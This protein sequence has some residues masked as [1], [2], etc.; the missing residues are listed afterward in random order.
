MAAFQSWAAA[1]PLKAL[2]G[3][4][5]ILGYLASL[6]DKLSGLNT[7]AMFLGVGAIIALV[8]TGDRK[9]AAAT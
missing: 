1:N 8:N 9:A 6:T 4:I 7:V 3:G 5:L 2:L